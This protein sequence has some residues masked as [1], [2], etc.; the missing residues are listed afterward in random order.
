MY[1][2]SHLEVAILTYLSENDITVPITGI[3]QE[4]MYD[5]DPIISSYSE[6]AL[7]KALSNLVDRRIVALGIRYG[8]RY[9]YYLPAEGSAFFKEISSVERGRKRK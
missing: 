4:A 6:S 3:T 8:R 5:A 7:Y 2:P 1:S 9:S